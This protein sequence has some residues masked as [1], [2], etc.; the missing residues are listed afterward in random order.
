DLRK[1]RQFGRNDFGQRVG[2]AVLCAPFGDYILAGGGQRSAR[3]TFQQ[4]PAHL[5]E[6]QISFAG[7]DV[8]GGLNDG[9]IVGFVTDL[10]S[11]QDDFDVRPDAFEGGDDLGGGFDVP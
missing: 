10:R 5:R 8:V 7:D 11:A 4:R 3:P 2:R 6:F 9:L 1:V